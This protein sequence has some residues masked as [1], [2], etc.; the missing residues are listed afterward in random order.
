[1]TSNTEKENAMAKAKTPDA[2]K[3]QLIK[4]FKAVIQDAEDLLKA[5]A[6]QTN[7]KVAG[8]RA[9]A[10]EN[11]NNARRK[12]DELEDEVT[13]RARAAYQATDQLLHEN[14]WQSVGIAAGVGFLLGMLLGRR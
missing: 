12:L 5:T 3:E 13:E 6:N 14:P 10:E 4:D 8:V 9:R 11:I 1:L 7:D 2:A